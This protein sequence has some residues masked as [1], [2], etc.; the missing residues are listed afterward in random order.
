M[1][2][3]LVDSVSYDTMSD[4][5]YKSIATQLGVAYPAFDLRK[6]L[7]RDF[8]ACL[9]TL[10]ATHRSL[11]AKDKRALVQGIRIAMSLCEIDIGVDFKDGVFWKSGAKL[12]D[13]ELVNEPLQW[14]SDAKYKSV[15]APFKKGLS[16]F[17][18]ATKETERHKDV[19]T[20]MYEALEAMAKVVCD[21]GKD[22]SA[23][24]ESF[25]SRLGLS[26]YYK[27]MMRDFI[28][29]ANEFRHAEEQRKSRIKL[30]TQEVEAFV[31]MTGLY[32]RLAIERLRA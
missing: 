27:K 17:L 4:A 23:N 20:D 7:E 14:L 26:E 2:V 25:V 24:R 29:F 18:L 30:T 28:E 6:C 5:I 31:Y 13:E 3:S 11:P 19:V 10:E 22:L 21:N 12:L 9:R 15:L 8:Y 32:I 1:T 16:D